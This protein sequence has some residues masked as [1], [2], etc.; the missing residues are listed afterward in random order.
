MYFTLNHEKNTF[1]LLFLTRYN[2]SC[3]NAVTL[4]AY[5][6]SCCRADVVRDCR[7]HTVIWDS[8]YAREA[9][10]KTE[11]NWISSREHACCKWIY[12]F[13]YLF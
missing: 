5:V 11:V 3:Y 1:V 4:G 6:S 8:A 7:E 12:E 9:V 2:L 13:I 10:I